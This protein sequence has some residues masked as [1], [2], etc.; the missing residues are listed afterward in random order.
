MPTQSGAVANSSSVS[1]DIV[2][3]KQ[4]LKELTGS[5][6]QITPVITEIKLAYDNYNQAVDCDGHDSWHHESVLEPTAAAPPQN[7]VQDPSDDDEPPRNK[8]KKYSGVLHGMAKV[9]NKP[10]RDGEK[11]DSELSELVK[12]LLSKGVSKDARDELL[13]KCPTPG[14][15]TRLEVVRVNPEIFNSVRKEI[16][17]E[18]VM[19]QKAQKLLL[20]TVPTN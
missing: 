17:T 12:Q 14:N 1:E 6:A 4:Q 3:I 7:A 11:L 9:V 8:A 2:D 19:L 20:R 10:Q 16:K 15:C 5:L 13:D 18:N